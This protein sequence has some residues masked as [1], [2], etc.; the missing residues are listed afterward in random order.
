MGINVKELL[1]EKEILG[2][3][4]GDPLIGIVA[5]ALLTDHRDVWSR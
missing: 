5:T 3:W 2:G 1:R 4:H